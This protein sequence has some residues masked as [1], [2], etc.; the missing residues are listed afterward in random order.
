MRYEFSRKLAPHVGFVWE[1][2][3]GGTADFRRANREL[4][5]ERR[6]VVGLRLWW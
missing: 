4:V 3:L 6:V 5:T 2:A 1:C